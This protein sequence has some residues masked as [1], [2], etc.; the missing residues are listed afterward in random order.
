MSDDDKYEPEP[1]K[2]YRYR[3]KNVLTST[4]RNPLSSY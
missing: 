1:P 2:Y 4:Y 3:G